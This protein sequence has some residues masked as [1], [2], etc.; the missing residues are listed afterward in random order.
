MLLYSEAQ[1]SFLTDFAFKGVVVTL[2]QTDRL[3]SLLESNWKVIRNLPVAT[4][5]DTLLDALSGLECEYLKEQRVG[6]PLTINGVVYHWI[7]YGL[8]TKNDVV[9]FVKTFFVNGYSY[10]QTV[11]LYTTLTKSVEL[12]DCFLKFL[13]K[14][15]EVK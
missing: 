5:D 11:Q 12:N 13:N 1:N 7:A 14:L 9:S 6:S 10:E 3:E 4:A 8:T 2:K 15:W